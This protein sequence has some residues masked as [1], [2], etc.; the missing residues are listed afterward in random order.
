MIQYSGL[1]I[2][3]N[4]KEL[5]TETYDQIWEI[6]VGLH[7]AAIAFYAIF[8]TAPLAIITVW[9]VSIVVGNHLGEAEFEQTIETIAGPE[10]TES[11][12]SVVAS[13]AQG[14]TGFWS[15]LI[16]T[17][18]LLFG[19]TTLLS[20]IKYTLNLIWGLENQK[21]G[22]FMNFLWDRLIS[23]LFIGALSL[24]FLAGLISE[25]IIY[26]LWDMLIPIIGDSNLVFLGWGTSIVNIILA[27]TFFAALFRILPDLNIRWRD[28]LVG[29]IVTTILVM[30]GKSLVD[31]YLS[32]A[33]L[34]P[35]YKA[36]GSFVVFLVWIY[37]NIQVVLVGAV[38]TRV[39]TQKFGDDVEYYW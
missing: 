35:M 17:V 38:F 20:Q 4:I 26:S 10:L 31:L 39:Y 23:L 2:L 25:S 6:N 30:A 12:N 32:S 15:S 33:A 28:I 14:A 8:S 3:R 7:G 19:A 11:I 13:T 1:K 16:A 29:A 24:L 34:Q 37:Y 27:I 36:A 5:L 18:T 9:I 22:S 21:L